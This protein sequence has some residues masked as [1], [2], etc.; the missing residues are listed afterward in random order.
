[1]RFDALL[2]RHGAANALRAGYGATETS[3]LLV[4]A[5]PSACPVDD[6]GAPILGGPAAGVSLRIVGDDGSKLGEGELGHVEAFAPQTLFSGYW[7][8][9]E[10]SRDCM[11]AD[12]WYKTGDLGAINAAG[13]SFRGRAKQTLVVGGRKFS[14]DDIDACLQS[15][16]H[17][18]RQTVSFVF[19]SSADATDG[20]GVA[21]AVSEGEVLDSV[22]TGGIRSALIRRYG[23]AP[24]LVTPVRSG[25]WPLTATGKVDRRA[26]AERA[27]KAGERLGR[28]SASPSPEGDEEDVLAFLWRE[29]LNLSN[30]FGR[31]DDFFDCG[32]DSMRA[33]YLLISV[34]KRFRR[35]FALRAFFDLP[36]F[37][38]LLRL[39]R[40][41][42]AGGA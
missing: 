12:G 41:F 32:G 25:E 23:F 39:V 30:D 16:A 14:L 38:N 20:L 28:E 22:S 7:K 6:A 35:Q 29:A 15:D 37:N 36:T 24:A 26:L 2:R 4:G 9:P 27:A 5:D 13:F 21:V 17:I 3:S 19:R 10:L 34:D 33:A 40:R 42:G 11:T 31:D 1:M 8:E 18:G